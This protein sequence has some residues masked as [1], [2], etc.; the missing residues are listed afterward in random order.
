MN[1]VSFEEAIELVESLPEDQRESL[2]EIVKRRLA[3]ERRERIAGSIRETREEFARGVCKSGT[4]EDLMR[5][6][7]S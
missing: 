5:D 3:E 6:L 1:P 4:V 2:I 7:V